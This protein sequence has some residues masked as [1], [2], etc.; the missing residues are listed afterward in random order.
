MDS[1]F[2]ISHSD[3]LMAVEADV[4]EKGD[5]G[6]RGGYCTSSAEA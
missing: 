5:S 4:T 6:N 2:E 1:A 3:I